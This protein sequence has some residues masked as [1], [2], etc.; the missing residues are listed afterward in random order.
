MSRLV[1]ATHNPGKAHE[2]GA[3]LGTVTVELLTLDSF[4]HIPAPEETEDSYE[5]N[6]ILK[7]RYYAQA[8]NENV[9]ADDSGLEVSALG[10]QPGVHSA[11][12]SGPNASDED[13]RLKLLHELESV[14]SENRD[15]RFVCSVAVANAKQEVLFVAEGTCRGQITFQARGS[16][17][18][19]Y[20]PIFMPTGYDKTFGELSEEIKN[21]ISHRA[22]ALAKLRG[23]LADE[24]WRA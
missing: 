18:F 16:S 21:Q 23:F 6:A 12:Y 10:G 3:M 22:N 5:G 2:I 11:R 1:I 14:P 9:L 7:A 13:R 24:K 17:G 15:A 20:D 8:L 19:G 4:E